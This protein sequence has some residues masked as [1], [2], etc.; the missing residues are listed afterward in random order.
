LKQFPH[1]ES[2]ILSA[3]EDTEGKLPEW[4]YFERAQLFIVKDPHQKLVSGFK[5]I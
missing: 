2:D 5:P 3:Y 4:N 1:V